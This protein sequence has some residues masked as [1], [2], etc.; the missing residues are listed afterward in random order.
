[1]IIQAASGAPA[2]PC[3]AD[4]SETRPKIIDESVMMFGAR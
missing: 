2:G 1:M 3:D 4:Q